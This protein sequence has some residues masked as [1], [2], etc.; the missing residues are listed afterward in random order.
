[1]RSFRIL[2]TYLSVVFTVVSTSPSVIGQQALPLT[3]VSRTPLPPI[4]VI[5]PPSLAQG[6]GSEFV[7]RVLEA[8]TGE[9]ISGVT[10]ELNR[11]APS[12]VT[13]RRTWTYKSTTDAE[14]QVRFDRVSADRYSLKAT[15]TGR[16]LVA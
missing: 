12:S 6:D 14:G 13:D 8:S 4:Q 16:T 1:M 15:L 3:I 2:L 7:V 10:I 9:P 5:D 11:P